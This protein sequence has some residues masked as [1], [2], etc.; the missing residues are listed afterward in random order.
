MQED[1]PAKAEGVE[2]KDPGD[3]SGSKLNIQQRL[4]F[5]LPAMML[6]LI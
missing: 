2:A 5:I 1:F 6:S 3:E 4:N